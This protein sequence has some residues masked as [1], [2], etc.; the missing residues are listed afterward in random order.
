[1]FVPALR[2]WGLGLLLGGVVVTLALLLVGLFFGRYG[3]GMNPI[4]LLGGL[5]GA[6][7][8]TAGMA[9][10]FGGAGEGR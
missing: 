6:L 2:E 7:T 3:L 5:A 1:V 9:V 4:L 8:M 10:G